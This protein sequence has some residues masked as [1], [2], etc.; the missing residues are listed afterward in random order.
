VFSIH[1]APYPAEEVAAL[2]R[3]CIRS[4]VD[5]HALNVRRRPM[6]VSEAAG[7]LAAYWS[8]IGRWEKRAET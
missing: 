1:G 2:D 6:E 5:E 8:K 7:A 3:V 4:D